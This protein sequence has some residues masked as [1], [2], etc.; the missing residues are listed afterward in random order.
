MLILIK[1]FGKCDNVYITVKYL[2][3]VLTN[4]LL[5]RGGPL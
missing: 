1:N 3:I 2:N 4:L 5:R